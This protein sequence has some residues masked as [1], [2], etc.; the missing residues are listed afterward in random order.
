MNNNNVINSLI[1][2]RSKVKV[3]ELK[4][5]AKIEVETNSGQP[6]LIILNGLPTLEAFNE[7]KEQIQI[8]GFVLVLRGNARLVKTKDKVEEL[9][10][11]LPSIAVS[12]AKKKEFGCTLYNTYLYVKGLELEAE[13][14]GDKDYYTYQ[15][16]KSIAPE[17]LPHNI[18]TRLKNIVEIEEEIVELSTENTT[19]IVEIEEEKPKRKRRTKAE[20]EAEKEALN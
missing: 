11:E 10:G 4:E 1:Q 7:A 9:Y 2:L 14:R 18:K 17:F 20:I 16:S 5:P 15:T 8:G 19:E 12:V 6:N 3:V 13:I